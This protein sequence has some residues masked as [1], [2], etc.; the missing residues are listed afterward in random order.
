MGMALAFLLPISLFSKIIYV[1]QQASGANDGSSWSNAYTSLQQALQVAFTGDSVWVAQGTYLPDSANRSI[2]FML[3][4]GVR[5]FGGFSGT[6]TT[7]DQRNWNL[8][9]TVLSGDIGTPGDDSD[10]SYHVVR[11]MG[12]FTLAPT[13]IDGFIIRAGRADGSGDQTSWDAAGMHVTGQF[14][15]ALDVRN[16]LFENNVASGS[17]GALGCGFA[18]NTDHRVRI[19]H[20]V[21]RNNHADFDGG[22]VIS[23]NASKV[24]LPGSFLGCVFENNTAGRNGGAVHFYEQNVPDT[25]DFIDCVFRNNHAKNLGGGV[26]HIAGRN[27][28]LKLLFR[29]CTFDQN[30][31]DNNGAAFWHEPTNLTF[32]DV[33][34]FDR[35]T[36]TR[37]KSKQYA[38]HLVSIEPPS[39]SPFTTRVQ[40]DSCRFAHNDSVGSVLLLELYGQLAFRNSIFEDNHPLNNWLMNAYTSAPRPIR[41]ENLLFRR[42]G[43]TPGLPLLRISSNGSYFINSIFTE[44]TAPLLY[45]SNSTYADTL[46]GCVIHGNTTKTASLART[47]S[48][49]LIN[50]VLQDSQL[51]DHYPLHA[52]NM[53]LENCFVVA[54]ACNSLPDGYHCQAGVIAG[55]DPGFIDPLQGDFRPSSC[56]PLI[57]AGSDAIVNLLDISNDLAGQP[58]IQNQH[59]D[60]GTFEGAQLNATVQQ[61][62]PASCGQPD[63]ELSL[64]VSN[65]CEPYGVLWS[66]G[67]LTGTRL[68]SLPSGSYSITITDANSVSTV[69]TAIVTQSPYLDG[70]LF[71]SPYLCASATGGTLQA[72]IPLGQPPFDYLWSNGATDS[73]LSGLLPGTYAL[74]LTD[75]HGCLF[76]DSATVIAWGNLELGLDIQPIQCHGAQNGMALVYPLHA[77][78]PLSWLWNDN[79]TDSL[80]TNLGPGNYAVTVTDAAGCTDA[81]QFFL[82]E[83]DSLT[84]LLEIDSARCHGSADGQASAI[85]SGG[86]PPYQFLWSSGHTTAQ[87]QG[88]AAGTYGLSVT[89]LFGCKTTAQITIDQPPPLSVHIDANTRLCHGAGNAGTA[90]ASAIGGTPG[91]HFLW[92]NGQT[93][94][95]IDM[96][97]EGLYSITVTDLHGCT[98]T[99]STQ[100]VEAEEYIQ[101]LFSIDPASS[102]QANDGSIDLLSVFGSWPPY[103]FA[104]SH[105]DTT[106]SATNLY[107]G[108]Y[109]LTITDDI[110]CSEVFYFTVDVATASSK[111]EASPFVARIAP[112]PAGKTGARLTIEASAPGQVRYVVFDATGLEVYVGSGYSAAGLDQ[113]T[114]PAGLA[115]GTYFVFVDVNGQRKVLPWVVLP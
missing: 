42:N 50:C 22:A 2:S 36:F 100:L 5:M 112:N 99:S 114:L 78:E 41:F 115:A 103:S 16:C 94:P 98:A 47:A 111:R 10:N 27:S 55:D 23:T 11:L 7:L 1:D 104:W 70:Q 61:V 17:G 28:G 86:T 58:R 95:A 20:C 89:D 37:H 51:L 97:P 43:T 40:F 34:V 67:T 52:K 60:I 68:D 83:P 33:I 84:L 39:G 64:S 54:P 38:L 8:Y 31:A 107:P 65:G 71:A 59:V 96:L 49:K 35:C 4:P 73:L 88:L 109:T 53:F 14:F 57:D 32:T 90:N 106:Q 91:Y 21:F 81:L 75:A 82:P 15:L 18:W 72:T 77:T 76:I 110:G 93:E 25:T 26:A 80:R 29:N 12:T 44:N 101:A 9:P 69:L 74:T 19:Q 56:S 46:I 108:F 30:S 105:G 92:S 62:Q 113:Y 85:P 6:E 24:E 45:R 13:V 63:G 79:A 87:A 66:N 48:V 102:A 3:R